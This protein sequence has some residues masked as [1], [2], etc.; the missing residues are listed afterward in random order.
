MVMRP[1]SVDTE[2][3]FS[4]DHMLIRDYYADHV[5]VAQNQN[6]SVRTAHGDQNKAH[7]FELSF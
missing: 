4:I 5:L 7:S 3:M 1:K 6:G 2:P